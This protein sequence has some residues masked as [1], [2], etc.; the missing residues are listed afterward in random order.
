MPK[1]NIN[2]SIR[3]NWNGNIEYDTV[4]RELG[5]PKSSFLT[6]HKLNKDSHPAEFVEAFLPLRANKYKNKD[7]TP[8]ISLAEWQQ[9]TNMKALLASAGTDDCYKDFKPFTVKEIQQQLGLYILNGLSPSPTM[10]LKFDTDDEANFNHFVHSNMPNGLRRH[11][12]FKAFFAVQDP[13]KVVPPR[14]SSP[15]FKLLPLVNWINRVG[16]VSWN[17]GMNLAVDEQTI[18]F[19]GRHVDK[20]H[21]T[22]KNEGDGFQA[23]A[24]CDRGFTYAAYFRNEK[25]PTKYIKQGLSP[26]HARVMWL[27]DRLQERNTRVWMDN[28]YISAKFAKYAANHD[29]KVMIAGVARKTG[30]GVPNS[31]LQEEVKDKNAQQKV[32]GTVKAALLMGDKDVPNLVAVSVYDT[33]PVHF[34]STVCECIEWVLKT[35]RVWNEAKQRMEKLG[36]L[37][38]NVNDDYNRDM[39]SVDIAD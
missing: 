18:G 25:P 23:D 27:F 29:K 30:R 26:L 11:R 3:K 39:N 28:L 2:G 37:R 24:L 21:I 19:Q 14:R 8:Y 38:L 10:D 17:L 15:L 22:Y 35:R 1:T 34:I 31:V 6:K 33:K 16:Q 7:N 20:R 12:H 5:E 4:Q 32:R 36:F 13:R 9:W